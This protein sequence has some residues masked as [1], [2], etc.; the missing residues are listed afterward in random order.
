M[1]SATHFD[2]TEPIA[3][4][5][6]L[7]RRIPVSQGWYDAAIDPKPL[8]Q[9]FRA[10]LDDVTGLSV[11]RG[12]PYNTVEKAAQGSSKSGYFVV[13]LRA[14]DLR[15]HG[16]DIVPRP[17]EGIAGHAEITNL[18]AMNRDTDEAQHIMELLAEKLCLRV[19]G[20]FHTH[21]D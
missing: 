4:D 16:I 17:V 11:V 6:L 8:L 12:E 5:E 14:G 13:V 7:Y 9:A 19:E 1:S 3:D 18:T 2:G 15:A 10:R 20:P 21:Q